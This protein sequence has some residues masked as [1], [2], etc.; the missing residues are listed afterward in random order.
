M[1]LAPVV[2]AIAGAD[3]IGFRIVH[4]GQ[5]Y[6]PAMNDVFF[7]E[8]KIPPPD[9][10][11]GVGSGSHGAQT[12]RILERYEAELLRGKP[13]ATVV[14]GDVNSTL[15]CALAAVKLGV[16]VVH[17]E[18]G[19]RSND[20]SMP[21]EINRL[22]TDSVADLLLTTEASALSN[23]RREGVA[24]EKIRFVGNVMIDTLLFNLPAARERETARRLGVVG[25]YGLVTLHRPVNV[26]DPATASR[27]L[28]LLG[29]LAGRLPL[30]F[31][32]HPRTRESARKAGAERHLTG[33]PKRLLCLAPQS[34]LDTLSLLAGARVVLTD[35]GGLQEES[36]ALRVPCLTLRD[37]TER[38]CTVELG[39]SRLVG[40]DSERIRAA[41]DQVMG[42]AWPK[43]SDIP[44]WD[45]QAGPRVAASLASWLRGRS[46]TGPA[47]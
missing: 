31:P 18:A 27:L 23:L 34:Y 3:E 8:L 35:S 2:R 4:T 29:Q 28:E 19:L 26:D 1:K 41:F 10:H 14:F 42:G 30:V 44:L 21:E 33:D 38:P 7:Q 12:A 39:T 16:P 24:E 6:D 17:V 15:A 45:G 36:S 13:A 22:V 5:H 37:T 9:V 25:S 40:R 46:A 43:G 20:R 11:L 32:V 47:A